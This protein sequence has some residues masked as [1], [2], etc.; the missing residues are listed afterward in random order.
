MPLWYE[1]VYTV[2]AACFLVRLWSLCRLRV[3]FISWV[4]HPETPLSA[5]LGSDRR[6]PH[7]C[8]QVALPTKDVNPNN[9][10]IA[11]PS[12]YNTL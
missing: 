1:Y 12:T 9:A 3:C 11:L 7:L 10:K 6:L 5:N 4:H 2:P 8:L